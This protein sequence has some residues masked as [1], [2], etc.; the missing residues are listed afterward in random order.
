MISNSQH[1]QNAGSLTRDFSKP[2]WVGSSCL[3][4]FNLLAG[5]KAAGK[6]PSSTFASLKQSNH[7]L[8]HPNTARSESN[9]L[10]RSFEQPWDKIPWSDKANICSN[11]GSFMELLLNESKQCMN[12]KQSRAGHLLRHSYKALSNCSHLTPS[13]TNP[14]TVPPATT[15]CK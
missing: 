9:P 7:L 10:E 4:S 5:V 2:W 15:V 3:E 14:T 6:E 8:H 11:S 1:I 13:S 12:Y